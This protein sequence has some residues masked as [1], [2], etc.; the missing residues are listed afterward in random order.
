MLSKEGVNS[1]DKLSVEV[2]RSFKFIVP[3]VTQCL[4][5]GSNLTLHHKPTQVVVHTLTGPELYSKYIYRCRGCALSRD[6]GVPQSVR[7]DVSYHHDRVS[8][9]VLNLN[10]VLTPQICVRGRIKTT[11]LI[12]DGEEI[13][14]LEF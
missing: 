6:K 12:N 1:L 11:K 5:C 10:L 14:L 4:L 3:P 7:Q 2:G 13:T 9:R 8:Y